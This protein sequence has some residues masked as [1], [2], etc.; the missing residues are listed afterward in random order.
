MKFQRVIALAQKD[1]KRMIREPAVL[2][3]L[4]LFPIVLTLA[5]GFSFGAVGGTGQTNFQVGL[6]TLNPNAAYPE[7]AE[8]F[9]SGM[10]ATQVL[11]IQTYPDNQTA[12]T[13]LVQGK[14]QAI[15]LIPT[16]FG[17][18]VNTYRARPSNPASWINTTV[19]MYLDS[20]SMMATQAIPPIIQQVLS[21][22]VTGNQPTSTAQPI[23]IGNPA[24]VTVAKQTMFDFMAPG[25]FA[26][27]AIFLTMTVA[28]TF[29]TDRENG[30][31]RRIN[32]TP[33]SAGEVMGSQVISNMFVG[34]L[35]A[36]LIFAMAYVVG[37]RPEVGITSYVFAFAIIVVFALCN[38]GFGL[39]TAT[40]S[41]SS[42]AATGIAFLFILPQMFLGT[43]VGAALSSSA[44][45]VGQFVP[46]Y[47]V[48]D[49]L[50]SLFLRKAPITSGTVLLD[51]GI[52]AAFS[53]AVLALGIVI[54]RKYGK[55]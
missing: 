9:T 32:V 33:T 13:E 16:D 25:L 30:M 1:L 18:S 44:Q 36:L 50:T 19:P 23:Q 14:I 31:L 48:T 42:S 20:G 35:Q 47:Y 4:L 39:I 21:V 41:K 26:Y 45:I 3:L 49:A 12:Q 8:L 6:V 28:Q 10:N 40:I 54:F 38:V 43:F 55:A 51:L 24:L 53:V 29:T 15:I 22:T 52:V 2:F 27:A 34:V 5:F 11:K 7:Y 37:Y 17:E 46:S